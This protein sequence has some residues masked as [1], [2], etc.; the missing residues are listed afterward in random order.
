MR[1]RAAT[2]FMDPGWPINHKSIE[3]IAAC[4]K[5]ARQALVRMGYEVQTLR[6]ATPP[7]AE[8]ERPVPPEERR[9]FARQLEAECFVHGIDYSAVGPV[10]PGDEA[11]YK[12]VSEIIGGTESVFT[13][14]LIADPE[15]GLSLSAIGAMG[16]VIQRVSTLSRDGFANLRFAALANV[17][18]GSPFFPA[19]Y[20]SGVAPAL[21]LA[22][23]SADLAVEIFQSANSLSLA[24]NRLVRRIE[25][26][27]AVLTRVIEPIAAQHEV[28]LLGIDFS[29]APF[30]QE[31][32]SIGV[33]MESLGLPA[34]GLPGSLT[35]AA[36]LA[37][38]VDKAEFPR[39]GFCGLILPV[40]E[41]SALARSAAGEHLSVQ[42]LLLLAAVC[43][44]GLDTIPLPGDTPAAAMSTLLMDLG[45]LALRHNKPLTA[46][47]MPIPE[48]AA[49]DEIEF[50]FDYFTST[51][52]MRLSEGAVGGLLAGSE[53][54]Q[55]GPI[56]H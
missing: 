17:A 40:L 8:M 23:E 42:D 10:L 56:A 52:V 46:R 13:S 19:A 12:V 33:A 26:N 47:L 30:P 34:V 31:L 55:L 11:G 43:G 18:P 45:A 28:R 49:G 21:A 7:P 9:E 44:A 24:R 37:D 50:D 2:G 22:T 1:I 53:D 5:A 27:A 16:E 25:G 36:F 39:T 38:C 3:S 32:R 4:L 29:L 35:A 15:G 6:L 41:D 54:V 20:H 51:R 48:K 14:A